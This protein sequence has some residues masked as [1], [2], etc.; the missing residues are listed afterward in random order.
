V[1]GFKEAAHFGAPL[2]LATCEYSQ[3][4]NP[5]QPTMTSAFKIR[6]V[7]EIGGVHEAIAELACSDDVDAYVSQLKLG[8]MTWLSKIPKN[9]QANVWVFTNYRRPRE[10]QLE[11]ADRLCSAWNADA[12]VRDDPRANLR[13]DIGSKAL[14]TYCCST[15]ED[16]AEKKGRQPMRVFDLQA[17]AKAA[18]EERLKQEA[19][20]REQRRAN[21]VTRPIWVPPWIAWSVARYLRLEYGESFLSADGL[22]PWQLK[23]LG[24]YVVDGVPTIYWQYPTSDKVPRYATVERFNDHYALGMTD[25]PPPIKG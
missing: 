23:R 24:E 14:T 5:A 16:L 2:S 11:F 3:P 8:V 22:K 18:E 7:F 9:A 6:S 13:V 12:E 1:T 21:P 25:E 17:M 4:S 10:V 19:T 15:F 20:E